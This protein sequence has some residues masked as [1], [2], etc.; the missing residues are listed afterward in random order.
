MVRGVV[1]N[2]Q[3][4]DIMHATMFGTRPAR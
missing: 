3:I 2:T 1:D 4:Y